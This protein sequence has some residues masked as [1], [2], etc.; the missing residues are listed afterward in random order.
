MIDYLSFG[1]ECQDINKLK[2]IASFLIQY[3]EE[4]EHGT[5]ELMSLGHSYPKAKELYL[6]EHLDDASLIEVLKQPNNILGI[7]YLKALKKQNSRMVPYT[8]KRDSSGYRDTKLQPQSSSASAIR[9]ALRHWEEQPFTDIRQIL[10]R[11]RTDSPNCCRTSFPK[12][13]CVCYGM[14]GINLVPLKQMISPF[15]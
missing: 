13:P 12:T 5:K 8:L 15:Y 14:H 9:N 7:E 6:R 4:I 1:S 11:H 3:K 10:S 2:Q